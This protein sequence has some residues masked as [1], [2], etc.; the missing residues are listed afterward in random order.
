MRD[1]F[2]CWIKSPLSTDNN[3]KKNSKAIFLP[4]VLMYQKRE[5]SLPAGYKTARPKRADWECSNIYLL[6][7]KQRTFAN[8]LAHNNKMTKKSVFRE[9]LLPEMTS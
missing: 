8:F 2:V 6:S 7:N 4:R 5:I 9:A 1:F 3:S